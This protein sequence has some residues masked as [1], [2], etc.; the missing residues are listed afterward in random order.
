MHIIKKAYKFHKLKT[1]NKQME[2]ILFILATIITLTGIV[3]LSAVVMYT[4]L[5]LLISLLIK[6]IK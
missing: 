2:S 3:L 5:N 1:R 6:G 4:M